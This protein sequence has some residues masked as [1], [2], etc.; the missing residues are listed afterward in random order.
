MLSMLD[1]AEMAQKAFAGGFGLR[2]V[3]SPRYRAEVRERWATMSRL[4]VAFELFDALVGLAIL[5]LGVYLVGEL[6][7]LIG[8]AA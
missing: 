3:L 5:G 4:E 6:I 8:A 1:L 2:F 7:T